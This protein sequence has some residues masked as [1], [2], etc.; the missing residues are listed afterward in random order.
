MKVFT[1]GARLA[2]LEAVALAPSRPAVAGWT[3]YTLVVFS[4][5]PA[6]DVW[7]VESS[8]RLSKS[9]NAVGH[10][11]K[12]AHKLAKRLGLSI[13]PRGW[14]GQAENY[15]PNANWHAA[16]AW[17]ANGE[18][19]DVVLA[20]VFP[21]VVWGTRFPD[22]RGPLVA[23][24]HWPPGSNNDRSLCLVRAVCL[25]GDAWAHLDTAEDA[26]RARAMGFADG[27]VYRARV[28]ADADGSLLCE[29][30]AVL[31]CEVSGNGVVDEETWSAEV[32]ARL[33]A[34]DP[35]RAAVFAN[36]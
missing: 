36:T 18:G 25:G 19:R 8:E 9:A 11:T 21:D 14:E 10:A 22:V 20:T 16:Q 26:F 24:V 30:G 7:R 35:L 23:I 28:R 27:E 15:S 29:N 12:A 31:R 5:A 6:D 2:F 13:P 3:G 1:N 33:P 32:V 34:D 17:V 4:R